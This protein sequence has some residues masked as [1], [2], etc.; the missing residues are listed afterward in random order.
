MSQGKV[1]SK[2]EEVELDDDIG[3]IYA[4]LINEKGLS[5]QEAKRTLRESVNCFVGSVNL[6]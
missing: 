5:F 3:E 6:D 4:Q 2:R 1:L